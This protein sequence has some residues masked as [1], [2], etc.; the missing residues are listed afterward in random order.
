MNPFK[1]LGLLGFCL[2]SLIPFQTKA[3]TI[4]YP[5]EVEV[6]EFKWEYTFNPFDDH[7]LLSPNG[8]YLL[9]S[10]NGVE[11]SILG[12]WDLKRQRHLHDIRL[13]KDSKLEDQGNY[14][15]FGTI[16]W[17]DDNSHILVG[18]LFC[19]YMGVDI[20]KQNYWYIWSDGNYW[21]FE[22]Y[23]PKSRTLLTSGGLRFRLNQ[24]FTK[25]TELKSVPSEIQTSYHRSSL[26]PDGKFWVGLEDHLGEEESSELAVFSM[27]DFELINTSIDDKFDPIQLP[28]KNVDHYSINDFYCLAG[29]KEVLILLN[30][31]QFI[32]WNFQENRIVGEYEACVNDTDSKESR[33]SF[34]S[35]HFIAS[36]D[37]QHFA[38][39]DKLDNS[40]VFR[41][42]KD[43]KF[44]SVCPI[45]YSPNLQKNLL[46]LNGDP[47]TFATL[48]DSSTIKVYQLKPK[49]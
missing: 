11:A 30:G 19:G 32:R 45:D 26:T 27:D 44:L 8:N 34:R 1:Q 33:K 25:F 4:E 16:A 40:F 39:Y 36:S 35:Y 29:S 38:Y 5:Y 10:T 23:A 17:L 41:E 12:V 42:V 22:D 6:H 14:C 3:Q 28:D 49:K 24:N 46:A 48:S 31:S 7:I 47:L 37:G 9:A 15:K 43:G 21:R 18:T 20:A 2:F 13:Y